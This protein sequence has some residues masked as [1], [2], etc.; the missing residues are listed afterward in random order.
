MRGSRT[1][2]RADASVIFE[3]ALDGN[4]HPIVFMARAGDLETRAGGTGVG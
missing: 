2:R 1:V 4:A 3:N